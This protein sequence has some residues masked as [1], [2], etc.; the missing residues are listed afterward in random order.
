M[1]KQAASML[2]EGIFKGYRK[3]GKNY[4]KKGKREATLGAGSPIGNRNCLMGK[5]I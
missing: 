3:K 4:K 1:V 5:E 2:W